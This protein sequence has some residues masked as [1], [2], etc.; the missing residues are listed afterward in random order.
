MTDGRRSQSAAT[1]DDAAPTGLMSLAHRMGEGGRRPGEGFS[2]DFGF[3]KY[4]APDGAGNRC[5]QNQFGLMRYIA[6]GKQTSILGKNLNL[7]H[8]ANRGMTINLSGGRNTIAVLVCA[9]FVFVQFNFA[10]A[11]SWT[12][13]IAPEKFWFGVACSAGGNKLVAANNI[14][15][16][17]SSI[18]FGATW[19]NDTSTTFA[20]Q[21]AAASADGRV[22]VAGG[23]FTW[24]STNSGA[25]WTSIAISAT[26]VAS[27]ADGSKLVIVKGGSSPGQ[28]Y[29]SGDSGVHWSVT[30]APLTKRRL[31]YLLW[32]PCSHPQIQVQLGRR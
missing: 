10:S 13:T 29:I 21:T 22:L 26:S 17:N 31:D 19:T 5:G 24:V 11:Q 23:N 14:G 12:K 2:F 28:I 18:D 25:T 7:E 3:Y 6:S 27:S 9:A 30:S 15:P 16:V 20:G 4:A 1:N 8:P 32:V